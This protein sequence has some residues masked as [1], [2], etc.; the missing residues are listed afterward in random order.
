MKTSIWIGFDRRD[1]LGFAVARRSA[2]RRLCRPVPV[3]GLV[4]SDLEARG[5]YVRPTT[6]RDGNQ[7]WDDISCAPMSTEFAISRFLVP[8][9]VGEG[10]ALFVDSDVMFRVNPVEL[11]AL[12]RRGKA[13]S[14]VKHDHKPT[15][16]LK[17]CDQ[18]Q[19][20][21]PRKAWS[22]VVVWDLD[23]PSNKSLSVEM[24]NTLPGRDLHAFCLS[25]I[26]I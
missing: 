10:L 11:F 22:S 15:Y 5:L 9:L 12:H 20:V 21:Y 19:T 13:V 18:A 6:W 26:H 8:H 7:L 14:V 25:L 2:E 3:R 1:A 16:S 24:I 17:M 4:L 23:H